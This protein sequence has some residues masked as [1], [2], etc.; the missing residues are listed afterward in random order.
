MSQRLLCLLG[1]T[2]T[3]KSQVAVE[4]AEHLDGEI[5]SVDSA[6]VYRTLDI[7]TAKPGLQVRGRIP[8][9]LIDILGV[10]GSY[11]AAQF[12]LDA[13]ARI[14][15]IRCRGHLPILVGGTFL[16]FRSLCSGLS[17]LPGA[18]PSVRQSIRERAEARGWASLHRELAQVDPSLASRIHVNDRQRI[19]RAIEVFRVT[20]SR[21][22]EL[23][24]GRRKAP[25][26]DEYIRYILWP[27]NRDHYREH[28]AR[29]FQQM[30]DDGLVTEVRRLF[31]TGDLPSDAPVRRLLGYRQLGEW[32]A[33]NMAYGEAVDQAITAT[34]RYAKRQ[35]TWLRNEGETRGVVAGSDACREILADWQ[36][37]GP[38]A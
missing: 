30:L 2:G 25:G 33:G 1:P 36:R 15:E 3:G 38:G 24:D 28:L 22:S 26:S 9:H 23:L 8:H 19:E 20:G 31:A 10:T 29:R 5:I 6:M 27:S 35:M 13:A 16:Y 11:N 7:G 18:C 12:A 32:L 37:E 4:L 21:P 17:T 14:R 34:R